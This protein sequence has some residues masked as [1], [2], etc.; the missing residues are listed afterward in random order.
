VAVFCSILFLGIAEYFQQI[1]H[2]H[3]ILPDI[4]PLMNQGEFVEAAR[5]YLTP[6]V[7]PAND[8]TISDNLRTGPFEVLFA[9]TFSQIENETSTNGA[10]LAQSI[11][12]AVPSSLM[13]N[14]E[15]INADQIIAD[16]FELE[17]TDLPTGILASFQSDLGFFGYLGAPILV[18]LLLRIYG[19]AVV[20][21]ENCMVRIVFLSVAVLTASYLEDVPDAL[22]SN[23]RD[24]A[25]LIVIIFLF[26]TLK[27]FSLNGR[28]FVR[29][30]GQS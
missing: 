18:V 26:G 2:N 14:K 6:T 17:D 28:P 13:R 23:A 10:V 3:E 19:K 27:H 12:N 7:E 25:M 22:L 16:A 11:T 5:L 4:I 9:M 20:H 1:R 15:Y 30:L 29:P 21:S 8:V 24:V